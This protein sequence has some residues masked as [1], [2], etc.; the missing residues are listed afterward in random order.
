M[1]KEFPLTNEQQEIF[2]DT[3]TKALDRQNKEVERLR[4]QVADLEDEN[5]YLK[6]ELG[7]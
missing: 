6:Q 5:R 3:L 4:R 2:I 1:E 7:R